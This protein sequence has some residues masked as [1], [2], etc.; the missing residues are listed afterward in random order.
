MLR[1]INVSGQKLIKM[2]DLRLTFESMGFTNVSTYI[3]SGNVIFN[4]KKLHTVVY[5]LT[6]PISFRYIVETVLAYNFRV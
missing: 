3:Q 2:E 1:G 5:F 4:S 6:E